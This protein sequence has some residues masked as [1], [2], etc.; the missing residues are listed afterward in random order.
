LLQPNLAEVY[1]ERLDSPGQA[2]GRSDT[3]EGAADAIRAL[4]ST[5]ELTPENG[6]LA[7]VLRGDLA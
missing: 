6:D 2:L 4:V 5:I 3:R 7:I 1:R